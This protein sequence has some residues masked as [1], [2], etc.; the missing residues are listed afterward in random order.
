MEYSLEFILRLAVAGLFA[1][2]FFGFCFVAFMRP[3]H[4]LDRE[5]DKT[6]LFTSTTGGRIGFPE[7]K[8]P[9]ISLRIYE[10]FVVIGYLNKKIVF[11][12]EDIDRVE[13]KKWSLL[14]P[15]G[16][17]IIHQ[18]TDVPDGIMIWVT[19]PAHVKEIIDSKIQKLA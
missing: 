17:Q 4:R 12:F 15:K 8:G 2:L 18:K 11:E 3:H 19:Q 5:K 16:I 14:S 13:I 7:Y 1:S 10:E 9:F 6:P